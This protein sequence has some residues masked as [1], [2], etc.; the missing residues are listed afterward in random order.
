MK[1]YL[2]TLMVALLTLLIAGCNSQNPSVS[3]DS[4]VSESETAQP[5]NTENIPAE[6]LSMNAAFAREGSS[7]YDNATLMMKYLDNGCAL[8]EFRLME[9]SE[10]EEYAIDTILS[11]VLMIED[12]GEGSYET[13]PDA[14]NPFSV[15]FTL[16]KDGQTVDVTHDGNLE[17]SPDGRYAFV[18]NYIEVSD[19]SVG[20]MLAFLPTATTS[21]NS[22][23]GAYTVEYPDALV[24]DWFY[25]VEAKFND[26]GKTLAKFLIAKDL[27]AVF[28]ADDDIEPVLIFGSAQPMMDAYIMAQTDGTPDENDG[29]KIATST[30]YEPRQL[31]SVELD[32][33]STLVPGDTGQLFAVIPVDLP[34]I[35]TAKSMDD[36][37][38]TV[39]EDGIVT[40]IG[41]GE[42]EIACVVTCED[43]IAQISIPV[44]VTKTLEV[45]TVEYQ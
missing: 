25:S 29:E 24:A 8:F 45:D 4:V 14:E 40:A 10:S 5:I 22:N 21:L 44:F 30:E 15:H 19:T 13:V 39:D 11:G 18:E 37:V 3:Q 32:S 17:I 38:A 27:S 34:Y 6:W 9:G 23:L 1:K 35:L 7:Q 28:R 2:I 12:N 31:I 26:S 16:S 20:E 33:G 41:E 36:D 42:T 43:G